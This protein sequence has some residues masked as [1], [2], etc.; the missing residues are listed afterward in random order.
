M[1]YYFGN[2]EK[3][4]LDHHGW[5][6]GVFME[7]IRKTNLFEI[8]Y[9]D[10]TLPK[11]SAK[12]SE[13]FELTFIIQGKMSGMIDGKQISISAGNYIVI[14]PGI[15]NNLAIELSPDLK[16]FTIKSPSDPS[17]KKIIE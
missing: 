6:V 16:G 9:F 4:S 11:H 3:D 14:P 1:E 15:P 12:I 10:R 5:F 7:D 8:K 13:T 2:Y 17:A